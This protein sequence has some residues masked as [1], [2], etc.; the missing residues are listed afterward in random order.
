M[1]SPEAPLT[2]GCACGTVRFAVTAPFE[3]AGYCHCHRCQRRTGAVASF[4]AVVAPEAF[5]VTAGQDA[6]RTWRPSQGLPK[7]F[8]GE[9]GGHVF[10]GDPDGD[11]PVGVRLGALDADPGIVP[12]WRQW[13][14]SMPEWHPPLP[15]DGTERFERS[16][17]G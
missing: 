16:R 8:C 11:K 6:V 14:E 10:A 7:A 13:L 5:A 3:S 17:F 1:P 9:C 12:T 2:G 4:N 15:D